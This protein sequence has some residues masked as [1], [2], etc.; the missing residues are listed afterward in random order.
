MTS[1]IPH[2]VLQLKEWGMIS[3]HFPCCVGPFNMVSRIA[4]RLKCVPLVTPWEV[5]A[6]PQ[7][8]ALR[9][10][11][12]QS[13]RQPTLVSHP[14]SDDGSTHGAEEPLPRGSGVQNQRSSSH[15]AADAPEPSLLPVSQQEA[16]AALKV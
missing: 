13:A 10:P 14:L 4:L 2:S 11:Y 9:E 7:H 12:R 6:R 16:L 1:H 3:K 5:Q 8:D 15:V